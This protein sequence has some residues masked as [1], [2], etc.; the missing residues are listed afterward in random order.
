MSSSSGGRRSILSLSSNLAGLKE[1][2][3]KKRQKVEGSEYL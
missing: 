3:E 1:R 2:K